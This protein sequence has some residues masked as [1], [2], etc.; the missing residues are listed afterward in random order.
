MNEMWFNIMICFM[1]TAS[2]IMFS[3]KYRL[4][5]PLWIFFAVTAGLWFYYSNSEPLPNWTNPPTDSNS[6]AYAV[7]YGTL[8]KRWLFCVT[9]G[10]ISYALSG[11]VYVFGGQGVRS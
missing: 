2:A 6:V 4:F 3:V 1:L 5:S 7:F 8:W 10:Y 11:M 9:M